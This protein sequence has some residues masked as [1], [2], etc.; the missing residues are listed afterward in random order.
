MLRYDMYIMKYYIK[1]ME[2]YVMSPKLYV[3]NM[4]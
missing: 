3:Y 1:S 4:I 2:R